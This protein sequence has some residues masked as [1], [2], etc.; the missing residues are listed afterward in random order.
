[1]FV[2]VNPVPHLAMHQWPESEQPRE[3]L[4]NKG[5]DAL[6]DAELLA[7][8]LH[9]GHK[10]KSALELAREILRL[11]GNNLS[12]LGKISVNQLQQLRGMGYAK[13]VTVIAAMELARRRQAGNIHKKTVI[14]N[15][16]DAALFFKP[17]LADHRYET[18]YVMFLNHANKVLHYR[19]VSHG[20]MTST[21]VDPRLIFREALEVHATRLV[22]CHNHPSG[23]LRPSQADIRI[24]H[25]IKEV[26]QLF[27]MEI[28]D[29]IIVAETGYCSLAEE[30]M[31]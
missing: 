31:L 18:F 14:R 28:L 13:A 17:L 19:C 20:G 10:S 9:T 8:L 4:V 6:N 1:M 5:P 16:A 3:K 29:H 2:N 21:V 23:N 15:G 26:G 25:K 22:L 24:T 27:D 30:G 12:E 7:I 11:A